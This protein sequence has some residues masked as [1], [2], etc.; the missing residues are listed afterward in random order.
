MAAVA[1]PT[2]Q[3]RPRQRLPGPLPCPVW[4]GRLDQRHTHPA[5]SGAV[6]ERRSGATGFGRGRRIIRPPRL[7]EGI[8]TYPGHASGS[9]PEE[10]VGFEP[11]G[12]WK[13]PG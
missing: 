4:L 2:T 8:G 11:T 1:Q 10:G 3:K 9:D 5:L 13:P 12:P 7:G 6:P